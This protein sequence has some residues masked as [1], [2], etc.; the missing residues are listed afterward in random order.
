MK[1]MSISPSTFKTPAGQARYYAAYEAT[2]ALWPVVVEAREAPTRFG[3][4]HINVCGPD[5]APP[6]VLLPG[7]AVS[8]TMWF[9]NIA[10]LSRAHRV[11]ALDILG[12]MGKSVSTQRLA[13]PTEFADW[14][15]EVLDGLHLEAAYVAGLSY[16][17]F[18]A[19]RLTLSTPERVTKLVLMS[20][21]SLRPIRSRFFLRMAAMFLP[22]FVLSAQAKQKLVL[23]VYSPEAVPVIK[24]MLTPT[25]FRYNMYL[26]PVYTDAELQ[27]VKPPTLLLLGEHEVIYDRHAGLNR[28]RTLIPNLETAI[29]PGAGHALNFD[30]PEMVNT[31]ILEFL[32]K[33]TGS[34]E[35]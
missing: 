16:G 3:L 32:Q 33:D 27:Q 7:Q 18:I 13:K 35:D 19:L 10:A 1:P 22:A 17:G 14:L 26:P 5:E 28:A 2:L 30:Q 20:P 9:P 31:R 6:L 23:G 34:A 4:T 25:D 24:Q 11:Y 15:N 29:I 8:S 21:A 12:D